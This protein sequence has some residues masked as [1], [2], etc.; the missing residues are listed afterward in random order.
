[1]K[2]FIRSFLFKTTAICFCLVNVFMCSFTQG[3]STGKKVTIVAENAPL[4][5]V[6]HQI[7][8]QTNLQFQLNASLIEL[9]EAVSY[10]WDNADLETVLG[11]IFYKR[12]CKWKI[13]GGIIYIHRNVRKEDITNTGDE[14][15]DT[16]GSKLMLRVMNSDGKPVPSATVVVKGTSMGTLTDEKGEAVLPFAPNRSK[17]VV[18]SI[19]FES[20]EW[21]RNA[22]S[23]IEI[24]LLPK[25]SQMEEIPVFSNG[26]QDIPQERAPGSF[27]KIDNKVLNEQVSTN[28]VDRLKNVSTA[29][30]FD[31]RLPNKFI[32]RG[33]SSIQGDISPLIIVDKFPYAGDINSINP[34]DIESITILKDAAATSIWGARAGN[35]VIVITTKKGKFNQPLKLWFNSTLSTASEPDLFYAPQMSSADLVTVQKQLFN[36]DFYSGA[37]GDISMPV[38]PQAVEILIKQRDGAIT[39]AQAA[40]QLSALSSHDIRNDYLKYVYNT[41]LTQ[42]Y[43]IGIS[44]GNS[45]SNYTLSGGYV[46][47]L[48]S[49]HSRAQ[50]V[51]VNSMYGFKVLPSLDITA[52]INYAYNGSVSGKAGYAMNSPMPYTSLADNSGNP[53]AV[54]F[55]YRMGYVDT[56]GQGVLRDW[57]YY[58]LSDWQHNKTT[59]GISN[60]TLQA[61][62]KYRFLKILNASI[63]YQYLNGQTNSYTLYDSSSF[64]ARN[65]MNLFTNV[66]ESGTVV[67]NVPI[68]GIYQ[69][70]NGSTVAHNGRGQLGL[71]HQWGKH[72]VTAI[73]GMEISQTKIDGGSYTLYGYNADPYKSTPVSNSVY[74]PTFIT[75]ASQTIPGGITLFPYTFNRFISYYGNASYTYNDKYILSVSGRRDAS[76]LFGVKTNAR[77]K[78]LWSVG[79]SWDLSKE[80]IYQF[81]LMP[82]LRLRA[83]YGVSGNVNNS[84]PAQ[85]V[86]RSGGQSVLTNLPYASISALGNPQLKWESSAMFNIGADF[87]FKRDVVTGSV[88]YYRKKGTD[89]IGSV[90]V[91]LATGIPG[92]LTPKNYASMKGSGVDIRINSLN[93]NRDFKWR[94]RFA[95]STTSSKVTKYYLS[96]INNSIYV[97]AGTA[98]PIVGSPL[99]QVGV[100]KWNGLDPQNGDPVGILYGKPSKDYYSIMQDTSLQD[101][102]FKKSAYPTVFGNISNV[103]SW[104][105]ITLDFN[106][107]Y[108]FSYYFLRPSIDYDELILN[109]AGHSDFSKRWQK[110]GDEKITNVPSMVYPNIGGRDLF[111]QYSATLLEKGAQIRFEYLNIGYDVLSVIKKKGSVQSLRVGL[112]IANLGLL[113]RANKDNIDPDYGLAIPSPKSYSLSISASF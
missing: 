39:D 49:L 111:Y 13:E 32:I 87:G 110:P 23:V 35:G 89:L 22:Q 59:T 44:G 10:K 47:D 37:E 99:Y 93:I 26:Y 50:R 97:G 58:P 41:P 53:L 105:G 57:H 95:F 27:E 74:Y 54:P 112:N 102:E 75:G 1:M 29:L 96:Y 62:I 101:L 18:S 51:T 48:T 17:I 82:S 92:G 33:F 68:G 2:L 5:K 20:T 9:K 24:R 73:V 85:T 71:E 67:N 6:L 106:I 43:S 108:K 78:P 34:N 65:L 109:G 56:V 42:Q 107:S 25:L 40:S 100:Y 104:K 94:T 28:I 30:L 98:A 80:D 84:Y 90:P 46:N 55:V 72:L 103:V 113:W 91:E 11:D 7:E 69:P 60:L 21:S 8:Q 88:E 81:A 3:K 31:N 76:N 38:L 45:N 15:Y 70:Y 77:W 66:N 52:G 4:I 36:A 86:I 79:G 14:M 12:G 64:Y 19:G 16:S 61:S 63:S 83:T